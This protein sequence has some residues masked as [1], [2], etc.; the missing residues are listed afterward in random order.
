MTALL[1]GID[2]P[3][4]LKALGI[5]QLPDLAQEIRETLIGFCT[6]HGGHLGS[7]LGA[8]ELTMALHYVFESPQDRI[9][10]DVSHQSYTHKI[11]TGRRQAFCDPERFG[12]VSG[13]TNSAESPHD[14]FDLGHTGTSISLALGIATARDLAGEDYA[15][16]ALI[17][18]GSLS[19]GTAF[20]GLNTASGFQGK[21][22][23]V[24][25]DNEMA[26]DENV[27]GLYGN[28]AELRN[29][30][31]RSA[32][33]IFKDLGF[34][35]RYVEEGNDVESLI[36]MFESVKEVEHPVIVHVHT[37]KALG[38]GDHRVPGMHEGHD[39]NNHWCAPVATGG[40]GG[41]DRKP[42]A[43]N[44]RYTYGS[45]AMRSLVP[46]FANEASLVVI[47]PAT[48][49]SNGILPDFIEEAGN[50]YIDVGIAEEHAVALACGIAKAGGAPVVATSSTFFQ[51]AYD[52][53]QQELAL[54]AS[55]VTL[56][57]FATGISGS[58]VTHSGAFDIALL[59][60]L[61]GITCL[62]PTS[63][64]ELLDMLAWSTGEAR[65]P[66]L[67]RM[68]GEEVL[69]SERAEGHELSAREA[70]RRWREST[71]GT[72]G[73]CHGSHRRQHGGESLGNPW[74]RYAVSHQ[75]S[76]VAL[77]GLG[78]A[79]PLA[80]RIAQAL[81]YDG[82]RPNSI[83]PTVIDPRQ[84]STVDATTLHALLPGHDLVVTLEDSQ[85]NGGWG[86]R[87]ASYY[88]ETPMRVLTIGADMA[89]T[90]RIPLSDL[91]SRYGMDAPSI[92]RRIHQVL[93]H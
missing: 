65:R 19:S 2:S 87:I 77:L 84:Y 18:D 6:A 48:A 74:E 93:G 70:V 14:H 67:I 50:H 49:G 31:G 10:F 43:H 89:F 41:G 8:V 56:L 71:G 72:G 83:D 86:H 13:F 3:E 21:L 54:N 47:S 58:D 64:Q 55:A 16:T 60:N 46:R 5:S 92:L 57:V 63:G 91:S 82:T 33:N 25:N 69:A 40:K 79:Y 9:I 66:V 32:H 61:P 39:R 51:R 80:M 85:L 17:G 29:S 28:L 68:P 53:I 44:A 73:Q 24:C 88:A 15:V 78:N 35:Y 12:S 4:D 38:I 75:G 27:G 90:D 36:G 34:D 1:D 52:Q 22:I 81:R 23:I 11:L 20:E 59:G 26:I 30:G 76:E 37:R 62:A 7:N 42:D 45:M